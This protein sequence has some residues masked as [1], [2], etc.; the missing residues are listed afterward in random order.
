MLKP[1][2]Q[3]ALFYPS[4][5]QFMGHTTN[6]LPGVKRTSARLHPS[7]QNSKKNIL[8][9]DILGF[10]WVISVI[11]CEILSD[12]RKPQKNP[13]FLRNFY[14]IFAQVER[15]LN[16]IERNLNVIRTVYGFSCP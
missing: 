6:F 3:K 2:I 1:C 8:V 4:A 13:I 9:F 5:M 14:V 7:W 12:H 16:V 15:N 11:F 10:F